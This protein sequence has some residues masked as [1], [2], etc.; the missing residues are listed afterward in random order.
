MPAGAPGGPDGASVSPAAALPLDL[1][2]KQEG[3]RSPCS[4]DTQTSLPP[5][6]HSMA[7]TQLLRNVVSCGSHT[8]LDVEA[9]KMR[10]G[11]WVRAS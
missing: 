4:G 10:A 1:H 11:L 2:G 9:A 7:L 5:T 6:P 3:S 8:H